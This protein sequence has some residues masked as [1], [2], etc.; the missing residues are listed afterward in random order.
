MTPVPACAL[1][2]RT[3]AGLHESLIRRLPGSLPRDAMVL[4]VG[5]GTGAWVS[6]LRAHGF[7]RLHGIDRDVSQLGIG[8]VTVFQVDLDEEVWGVE[9]KAFGLIT[10]IEVLEHLENPGAVLRK[11]SRMLPDDGHL[12]I[13]TPNLHSVGARAKFLVTGKLRHFDEFGDPTHVY[14]VF[15]ANLNK[16]LTRSG[17]SIVEQWGYPASGA[18]LGTRQWLSIPLRLLRAVLPEEVSGD[19][20]CILAGKS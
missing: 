11:L 3:V 18:L 4:D 9:G 2:E 5:C 7:T 10:M 13:T 20:L 6:R 14:P 1:K 8:D 19:V 16:L 12:L 17:L 15:L